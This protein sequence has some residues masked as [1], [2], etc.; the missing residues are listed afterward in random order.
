MKEKISYA[1]IGSG[2]IGNALALCARDLPYVQCVGTVDVITDRAEK[3][4]TDVGGK[5]YKDYEVMLEKEKPD[6]VFVATPE[7]DH[8]KPVQAAASCGCQVFCEKPIAL[9]MEDA[10]GIIKACKD[11][12]VKLM[13]GYPLHFEINYAMIKSS[14]EE[15][16]IGKFLSAYGR[17]IGT[18]QEARRLGGRVT[19]GQYIAVHDIDA[20]MWFHPVPIKSVYARATYGKLWEE[21]GTYDSAWI[22]MEFEDGALGIHEVGLCLPE[23]WANFHSPSTWGGFGDIRMNVIGTEGVLNLNFT[24]MNLY[25]CDLEGW[26]MPDTRHWTHM[27]GKATGCLKQEVEYFFEC[28][29]EDKQPMI[30][31]EDGRRSLEVML[32][33]EQ[34]IAE[35]RVVTLPLS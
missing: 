18:I 13:V 17:R 25:A 5:A 9:T 26:K 27:H 30:T 4:A 7:P 24:P 28:I 10:D 1:M 32:A 2:F 3:L 12:K 22:M 29:R 16:C 35:N 21:L 8:L 23:R 11:A 31:G 15:G 6:V 34:S 20:I 19:P 33:A 14:V